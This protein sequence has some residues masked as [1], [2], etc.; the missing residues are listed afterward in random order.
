[1][2][3]TKEVYMMYHNIV[4]KYRFKQEMFW[5]YPNK[6]KLVFTNKT[7]FR[8]LNMN[9]YTSVNHTRHINNFELNYLKL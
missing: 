3:L 2:G 9:E 4:L 6:F 5:S 7:S 8:C 1:M